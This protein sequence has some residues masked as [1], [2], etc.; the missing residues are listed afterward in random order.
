[1][2]GVRVEKVEELMA[3]A[4]GF[5]VVVEVQELRKS[6]CS[7]ELVPREVQVEGLHLDLRYYPQVEA[8]KT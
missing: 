6:H 2:G 8:S 1:M 7:K 5:L 4:G 3:L